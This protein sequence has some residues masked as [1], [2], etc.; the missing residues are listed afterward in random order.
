MA[1]LQQQVQQQ[2]GKR[3]APTMWMAVPAVAGLL[4]L[5]WRPS[6]DGVTICP[7]RNCTGGACPGCGM[8]RA[9][10]SLV[11]GDVAT[12]WYYHPLS[13]LVGLELVIGWGIAVAYNRGY[14]R[15]TSWRPILT[16]VLAIN[17]VLLVAVWLVRWRLGHLERVL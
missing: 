10:A 7:Y 8:T 5:L 3:F 9:L 15:G 2:L 13:P 14:L 17:A 16:V 4:L 6:D 1:A 11:K 12:A